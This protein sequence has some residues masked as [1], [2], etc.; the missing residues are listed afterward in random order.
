MRER[1]DAGETLVEIVITVLIIGISVGALVSGLATTS[2][3]GR[4]QR[5]SVHLDQ[6]L[7]NYAEATR[8]ALS[9]CA[10]HADYAVEFAAPSGYAVAASP[11]GTSCPPAASPQLVTLTVSGPGG[12]Q[13]TQLILRTP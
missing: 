7:R 1:R 11:A 3:V 2:S 8:S 12:Q 9:G 6:V 5:D 13:T 4:A 10:E